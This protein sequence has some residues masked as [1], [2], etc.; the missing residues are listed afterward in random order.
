MNWIRFP[1]EQ[2][3]HHLG[4]TVEEA[5][6]DALDALAGTAAGS[7]RAAGLDGPANDWVRLRVRVAV[8][9][10]RRLFWF[11]PRVAT[12][13]ARLSPGDFRMLLLHVINGVAENDLGTALG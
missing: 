13:A 11:R 8:A 2:S 9:V 4:A 7:P 6:A 5:R 1:V 12:A 3:L 10:A